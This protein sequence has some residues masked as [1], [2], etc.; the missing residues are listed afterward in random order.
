MLCQ[1]Y[2]ACEAP[3]RRKL[4]VHVLSTL[5]SPQEVETTTSG[6]DELLPAPPS[7]IEVIYINS[8]FSDICIFAWGCPRY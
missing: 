5:S 6:T 7:S 3:K 4:T 8:N 1:D 2:I